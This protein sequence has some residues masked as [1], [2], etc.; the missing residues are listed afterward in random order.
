MK[1]IIAPSV[2]AADFANLQRDCE[3]INESKADWFHID[4]MDGMFVPNISFGLP[5]CAAIKKHAKKPMDVHL[6]IEQPDRYL[7]AFKKAGADMIS[8]HAEACPH[9]HRS[10]QNI[11]ELGLKAGVA[12]NPHTSLDCLEFLLHDI[13][14]VCIMSVNP[15]FGGQKFIPSTYDKVRKLKAMIDAAGADVLIQIDGGVDSSNA[16]KLAEAGATVLVAGSYVFGAEDPKS[17]IEKIKF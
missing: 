10:I 11:K 12:L 7:E 14:Y 17:A 8:V 13:D 9:L 16:E 15:G 4:I 6:M 3:L 5:V 2:L 1:T